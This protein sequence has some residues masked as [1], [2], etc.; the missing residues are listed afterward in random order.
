MQTFDWQFPYLSQRM[1]V[2]AANVV[3]TSQPLAAQA[4]LRMLLAGG[5]AADAIVATAAALTV[6]E[7]TMNGIGSDAFALLWDGAVLHGLNASGHSPA[8]WT[9]ERFAT[10]QTMPNTGWDCVTVP[11]VVSAWVAISRKFGKLPFKSLLIPAIEYAEHG[12]L[13]SP[14][15]ARQWQDQLPRLKDQPGFAAGFMP[16]GRSPA[17]GERFRFPAQAR[18]LREIADTEGETFYRGALAERISAASAAQGGAMTRADLAAHQPDWVEPVCQDYRGHTLHEIPP[19]GQGIAALMTLGILQHLDMASLKPDST[20]AVHLQLEAMKLA[21]ADVYRNVSD[22]RFMEITARDML[23]PDYLLRRA[24]RIDR[25]RAQDFGHGLPKPSGTVYL[26][27]ADVTGMMVSYIQSN[28]MGFGSG[29]VVPDTGISLQN[30]GSGFSLAPGHP[31]Q[32]GPRKRPFHTI[33]PAF[34]T[35]GAG[36]PVMSFGVMGADMQPQGHV[37]MTVRLLDFAQNPQA[38][39]DGP[40]WK[41]LGGRNVIVEHHMPAATSAGL[42]ELGHQLRQ[43]ERWNLEFGSAQLI[44]RLDGGYLAASEPRRDGQAVGF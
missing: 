12:F 40:R 25:K 16:G 30:R 33:I 42:A 39:L 19:N 22:P 21:F 28:Y 18:T 5:N 35:R 37:Q 7:P 15:V 9:P 14:T 29:V 24:K 41:V 23:D 3:A 6:V 4:G 17:P 11:G 32:V 20:E 13:V 31:N 27:A 10:M 43:V 44:Y 8:A 36:S 26:T 38:A 2:L 1:P 34:L